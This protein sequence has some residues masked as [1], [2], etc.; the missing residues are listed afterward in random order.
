M[1]T[2]EVQFETTWL[3]PPIKIKANDWS[4]AIAIGEKMYEDGKGI[5]NRNQQIGTTI[6]MTITDGFGLHSQLVEDNSD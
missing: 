1:F 2:Y 6:R 5:V 3:S 4:E